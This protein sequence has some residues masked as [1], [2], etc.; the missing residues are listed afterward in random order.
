MFL[1]VDELKELTGFSYSSKQVE[2]LLKRGWKFEVNGR[3]KP[4]VAKSYFEL[5]MCGR[6]SEKS[7]ED[8]LQLKPNFQV[9]NKFLKR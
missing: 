7:P 1:T 4:K 8:S 5:K 9:L 6:T 3:K 2:W